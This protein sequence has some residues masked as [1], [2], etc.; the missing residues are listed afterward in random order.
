[1]PPRSRGSRNPSSNRTAAWQPP[2]PRSNSSA[3]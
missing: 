2:D 3:G 1:L